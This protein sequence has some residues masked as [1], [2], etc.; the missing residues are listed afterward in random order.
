MSK[1]RFTVKV[2]NKQ[3]SNTFYKKEYKILINNF[4]IDYLNILHY[5]SLGQH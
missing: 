3:D 1:L 5:I 4:Y 2:K